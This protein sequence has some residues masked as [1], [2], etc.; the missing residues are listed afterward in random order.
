MIGNRRRGV[1][2]LFAFYLLVFNSISFAQ[3]AKVQKSD[4]LLGVIF[5]LEDMRAVAM[6]DIQK[7]ESE[8]QK[9]DNIMSRSENIVRLA[10][11]QNNAKAE[12]IAR[13]ASSKAQTAK[14]KNIEL[15]DSAEFNKKKAEIALA[16]VKN[17]FSDALGNPQKIKSVITNYS[18]RV[19]IQK[20]SGEI[21]D[22]NQNQVSLLEKGDE[23][24]TYGDSSAE[25]QFLDGRGTMKVGQYSQIKMEEDDAGTQA[26]SMIRGKVNVSVEKMENYQKM[27][28]EKIK[29]YKEDL[30][31]VKDEVKQK[32]VDEYESINKS[33][34]E[35]QKKTK[36][37]KRKRFEVRTAMAVCAV[38][39]TQ[40]LVYE[41]EKKGTEVIVLE[42]SVELKSKNEN[43]IVVVNEGYRVVA[44]KDGKLSEPEEIDIS[45]LDWR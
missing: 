31:T 12:E 18:G 24:V 1:Y 33:I 45:N 3:D 5:K 13:E 10:Q 35:F 17:E 39:G 40:F 21:I 27:M 14:T 43:R 30:K 20:K 42:G 7:Y 9:C 37:Y 16:H 28:E 2:I 23:I 19:S 22:S 29:A 32:I 4:W 36:L 8:I 25:L 34:D 38:R 15:K 26:M 44:V 41:D 6:E 11:Q